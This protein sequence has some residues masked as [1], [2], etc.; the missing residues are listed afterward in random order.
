MALSAGTRLG[1]YEILAPLGAGGM[2]EVY[3]AKDTRLDRT[4]AIKVLPAHLSDDP[5][6]RQRLEREAR[7]VSSLNHPHICTLHDIGHQDGVD[8][9]VMEYLEGETLA[10]RLAKGPLALDQVLRCGIEISAALERAHRQ[11]ITHRDLKPGNIMLTKSGAKLLD[12]GLA[13]S[14]QAQTG[15][16]FANLSTLPTEQGRGLT[17]EGTILGTF[18]YMSPEQ[19]EGKEADARSDIF[20]FGAVLYEMATGKRAFEGK[21]HASVVAA[22][23]DR[24]PPPVSTLQSMSPPALDHVV[25]FCLAKDPDERWQ[26][27]HDIG[28]QL[29][30]IAGGGSQPD[31]P[32][33]SATRRRFSPRVAW[34]LAAICFLAAVALAATLIFRA[35]LPPVQL[36]RSSLPPPAGTSFVSRNFS[37]SPDGSR[38]AFVATR[39]DAKNTLWVR[40]LS[41]SSAQQLNGTDGAMFPFWSTDSRR[42]GFFAEGKLKT[43]DISG[44]APQIL[45]DAEVGR[46]ATWNGG[47]IIVFAPRIAG[48]LYRI[49]DSG[50]V[51]APVTTIPRQGSGQ[52]H[53][54]PSFLPDGKHFLYF[55]HWSAPEDNQGNGI[56]AGSL[57][58]GEAKLVSLELTGNVVFA[59]GRL[60]YANDRS[61]MAQPFDP[62][63][64]ETTGPAVAI[65]VQEVVTD[66][67]FLDSG[68]SVAENGVLV[69]Q[70]LADSSSR[71]MWFD[72]NGKELGLLP[73][74]GYLRP[75]ISPDGRFLAVDSDDD[76]NG[77]T[78]IRVYDFVREISTRLTDGG[79]EANPAWS[80]D[81]KR[82]TYV[83]IG[84]GDTSYMYEVAADGSGPPKLLLKGAW[85]LHV[86]WSPDG[87]LVFSDFAKGIPFVAVYSAADRQVMKFAPFGAEPRFSP[88]GKWIAYVATGISVQPF[89]GPG[90]RIQISAVGCAQPVWSRDGRR[91]FYIAPDK[92]L[93]E[94]SFDPQTGSAG[95]PRVLFQT[96]IIAPNFV[97]TQYDVAS[98]G[99]FLIN[100]LPSDHSSPLTLVTN[101]KAL[102]SRD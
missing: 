72:S 43:V 31:V 47:G 79:K 56:Y 102:K 69:F 3:R 55:V 101:W 61:L 65:A 38:L 96:R 99:R 2:G 93:M 4:V 16:A 73:P 88:D 37:V 70:S 35:P 62:D 22:I 77:K 54:W 24:D 21:S 30:W 49:A 97:G 39:P 83:V 90:G 52:A 95:T 84:R 48:P 85:M 34:V 89:P 80:H 63:R 5:E 10:D 94:V 8:F 71:L 1:P 20:S 78:Y 44:G 76:R 33:P 40:S 23:L 27:A 91:I 14:R 87:H 25:K 68:F 82:I 57:D 51:S 26:T 41:A 98:D 75:R 36:M 66:Q 100:S 13:T 7:A 58:G 45:C 9:L 32:F 15:P 67:G 53:R 86:D 29:Q 60:L 19:L 92:K 11:G 74:L 42:V 18:Q 6:R 81:G 50:G 17:E 46:G 64:L 12:F 59:S 28:L